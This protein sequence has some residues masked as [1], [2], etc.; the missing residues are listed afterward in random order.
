MNKEEMHSHLISLSLIFC[1][2]SAFVH[3]VAQGMNMKKKESPRVVWDGTNKKHPNDQVM[4]EDVDME[5]K[6]IITFGNAK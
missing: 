2:F 5:N 3:H 6:P 1:R 4:N